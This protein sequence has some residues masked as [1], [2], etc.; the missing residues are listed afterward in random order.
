MR[1]AR[2]AAAIALLA[3]SSPAVAMPNAFWIFGFD[4][5]GPHRISGFGD[6]GRSKAYAL[7]DG[8]GAGPADTSCRPG[9]AL[10]RT[11]ALVHPAEAPCP[12]SSCQFSSR[13]AATC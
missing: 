10:L 4:L 1:R 11:V 3:A 2:S 9:P 13:D 12:P 6:A 7:A 8:P 5:P